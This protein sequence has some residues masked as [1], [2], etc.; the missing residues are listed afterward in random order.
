VITIDASEVLAFG[1]AAARAPGILEDEA[2]AATEEL[3]LEGMGLAQ[4]NA[5]VGNGDL[6]AKIA[7]L[8]LEPFYGEYG[9]EDLDYAWMREEGGVIVPRNGEF[10]VFEIAGRL[11]FA[12]SV[13]Q[14]G[15]KYM[16]R[17]GDS[18]EP[19]V[20]PAYSAALDRTI[21]RIG[22]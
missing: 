6:K 5:P 20:E 22:E 4:E 1:V 17:S 16:E 14:E 9:I 15:T 2:G 21:A 12:R 19:Q 13:T 11:I 7:V 8:E 10:L 3:T 18:L